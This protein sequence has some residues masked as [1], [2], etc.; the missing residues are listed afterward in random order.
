LHIGDGKY[1]TS[2]MGRYL[3][4]HPIGISRGF[5]LNSVRWVQG[6]DERLM[7]VADNDVH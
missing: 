2:I 1:V 5:H 4:K 7:E 6:E 3:A